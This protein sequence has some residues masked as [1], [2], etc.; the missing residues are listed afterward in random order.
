MD[1]QTQRKLY[2]PGSLV[3]FRLPPTLSTCQ[4]ACA[5]P[6]DYGFNFDE[7]ELE[8]GLRSPT[9]IGL[10]DRSVQP[11]EAGDF[12]TRFRWFIS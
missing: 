9:I 7:R 8:N 6:E 5:I 1:S 4:T 12:E 3:G 2:H 10:L 11:I